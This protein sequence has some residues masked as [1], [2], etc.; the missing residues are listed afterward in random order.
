MALQSEMKLKLSFGD[1]N[2]LMNYQYVLSYHNAAK[3]L[4]CDLWFCGE[5]FGTVAQGCYVVG[6]A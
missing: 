4:L 5:M 2:Y 6:Q 1:T 3:M